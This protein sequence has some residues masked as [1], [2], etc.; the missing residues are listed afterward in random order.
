M[1]Y[2]YLRTSTK[3]QNL[4]RQM[5]GLRGLC[6]QLWVEKGIS[7]AAKTRPVFDRLMQRLAPGD[8]FIVWDLDRAFRSTIDALLTAKA[9]VRRGI[10]FQIVTMSIDTATPAGMLTYTVWAASCEYERAMLLQ[11]TR[12]GIEAARRRGKHLGRKPKLT[13]AQISCIRR[14]LEQNPETNRKRLALTYGVSAQTLRRALRRTRSVN[15][16]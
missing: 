15:T 12:Q 10:H 3:K 14:T 6:D 1:K 5:D 7:A 11:R 8:S 9:L 2:G 16:S 4:N 13:P